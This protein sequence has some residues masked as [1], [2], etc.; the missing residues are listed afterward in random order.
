MGMKRVILPPLRAKAS[1]GACLAE[2]GGCRFGKL[3]KLTQPEVKAHA[4]K[5]Q[6]PCQQVR[7][8]LWKLR[9]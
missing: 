8:A 7:M 2:E 1:K 4:S 3:P 6:K 5:I 9:W